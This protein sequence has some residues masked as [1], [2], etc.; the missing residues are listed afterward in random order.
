M[1][2]NGRNQMERKKVVYSTLQVIDNYLWSQRTA[3][4]GPQIKASEILESKVLFY[5]LILIPFFLC[6]YIL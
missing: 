1:M 4:M 3:N 2:A 6:S 5:L